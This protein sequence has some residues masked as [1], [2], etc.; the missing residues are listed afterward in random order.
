M[1]FSKYFVEVLLS[2]TFY[3]IPCKGGNCNTVIIVSLLEVFGA[4]CCTVDNRS[5]IVI[6]VKNLIFHL[7]G[8][9]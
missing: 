6:F 7:V 3:N 4:D 8:M 9:V 2:F 5:C 1:E